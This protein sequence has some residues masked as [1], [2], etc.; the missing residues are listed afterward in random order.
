MAGK[1]V[2]NKR[3]GGSK[4]LWSL[5]F[6]LLL[7]MGIA[8]WVGYTFVFRSNVTIGDKKSE[9]IYIRTGWDFQ[10]VLTMLQERKLISNAASFE[11][12]AERKGYKYAIKPGRYRILKN[13]SNNEMINILKAGIQE[14][15]EFTLNEIRTKEQLASRAGGKLELDS[16]DLLRILDDDER[17]EKYGLSSETAL[18]LFIPKKYSFYWNTSV[19]QFLDRMAE[20]YRS[21][22]TAERKEQ[23]KKLGLTQSEV[24]ILASIVQHE[25]FIEKEKSLIAGVYLN[26]LRKQMPLQADPTLIWAAKDFNIRRVLDIHKNIDSPYNT[27]R[28]KGLPP[29]PIGLATTSS[30][31]AVLNDPRH[32]YLYF[33][34]KPDLSGFTAFAKDYKE[35]MRNARLYQ[36]ALNKRKILK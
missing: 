23:A 26:R 9:F 12:L 13:M 11:W 18:T 10:D 36:E 28:Y 2:K 16:A 31:D 32:E 24:M 25:S 7:G 33:C 1:S 22:W 5:F 30:I 3:R 17:M 20:E 15:V 19:D 21:F 14:P 35:H 6:V 34:A 4:F 8:F 27:Y 29:G